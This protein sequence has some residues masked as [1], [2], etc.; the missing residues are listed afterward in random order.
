MAIA[1]SAV[2]TIAI[3]N[4][5]PMPPDPPGDPVNT[6]SITPPTPPPFP[7]DPFWACG[8]ASEEPALEP[9]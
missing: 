3:G 6:V 7:E 4:A 5:T 9:A 8:S 2:T 1:P